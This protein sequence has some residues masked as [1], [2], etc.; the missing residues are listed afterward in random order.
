M[1][2]CQF[3]TAQSLVNQVLSKYFKA[4]SVQAYMATWQ[5][6]AKPNDDTSVTLTLSGKPHVVQLLGTGQ[7][8]L[9]IVFLPLLLRSILK[10]KGSS[11]QGSCTSARRKER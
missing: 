3:E 9:V 5:A 10:S 4:I 8:R 11:V 1:A 7:P 6:E 2:D